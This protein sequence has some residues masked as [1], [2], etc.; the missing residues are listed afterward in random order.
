MHVIYV[1]HAVCRD[2]ADETVCLFAAPHFLWP[3]QLYAVCPIVSPQLARP[4]QPWG[5]A[6]AAEATFWWPWSCLQARVGV[7]VV[8]AT[9]RPDCVDAA[10][11]RPGRFDRLLFVPPPDVAARRAILVVHT[12]NT[13]LAADVH[14]QVCCWQLLTAI[15]PIII[16]H[17]LYEEQLCES[18]A[19]LV[20]DHLRWQHLGMPSPDFMPRSFV[21]TAEV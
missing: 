20:L 15:Y 9:N 8:G 11:L 21:Q 1:R 12:R 5:L 17:P 14:L 7:V 18:R 3:S 2:T 4:L 13:P 6:A 16:S 19:V 10:L